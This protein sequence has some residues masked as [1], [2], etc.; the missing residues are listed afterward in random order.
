MIQ[1]RNHPRMAWHGFS[2]WPPQWGHAHEP[3]TQ[4][5]IGELGILRGVHLTGSDPGD[6]A[7]LELQIEYRGQAFTGRICC[8]D[9]TFLQPLHAQLRGYVGHSVQDIGSL[10][11]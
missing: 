2:N 6:P 10:E 9:P 1:L 7:H 3:G 8:D 4:V 5:P 11:I